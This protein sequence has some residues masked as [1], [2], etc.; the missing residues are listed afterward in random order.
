[1]RIDDFLEL[2]RERRSIRKFKPNP[3]SDEYIEK[4]I[5]AGR[6]AMSGA[7]AQPW[8]FIVVKDRETKNKIAHASLELRKEQYVI[9]MTRSEELRHPLL[10]QPPTLPGFKDAPVLIVVIGD[11]RTF[12]ATVLA[13]NFI[14][15]EGGPGGAYVKSMGNAVTHMHL[16]AAALGLGSQWVSLNKI[17]EESVKAILDIPAALDVHTIV[18]IGYPAYIPKQAYRRDLKE[19]VH[20]EKYDRNKFRSGEDIIQYLKHL[21]K[22]TKA[23]YE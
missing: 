5:E 17:W 21:R 16:A 9:E 22:Q 8:E 7:N 19:L 1:M 10:S 3:I 20:Y 18:A 12:Q 23:A 4:I 6:W 13:T 2:V 14:A 11:K 15:G